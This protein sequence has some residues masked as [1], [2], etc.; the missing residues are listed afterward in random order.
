LEEIKRDSELLPSMFRA[1][2]NF[3]KEC[4]REKDEAISNMVLY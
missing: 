2:A 3:R 4:K 1:E